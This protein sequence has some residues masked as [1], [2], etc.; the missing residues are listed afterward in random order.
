MKR[1]TI[2]FL[3]IIFIF[4]IT[5]CP[6]YGQKKS[7]E[8]S[9]SCWTKQTH[10][11]YR[12]TALENLFLKY[13]LEGDTVKMN[14]LLNKSVGTNY[15]NSDGDSPIKNAILSLNI[16]AVH[17]VLEKGSQ[18]SFCYRW[19][20]DF[21]ETYTEYYPILDYYKVLG[22]GTGQTASVA[23]KK[24]QYLKQVLDLLYE[25]GYRVEE[26]ISSSTLYS[27]LN[28]NKSKDGIDLYDF[29]LSK[30]M[31]TKLVDFFN[32]Y[33][34][35]GLIEAKDTFFY[36]EIIKRKADINISSNE[37]DAGGV[38]MVATINPPL[39]VA[40]ERGSL[41]T[42]RWLIEHGANVNFYYGYTSTHTTRRAN[43]GWGGNNNKCTALIT[44][45]KKKN[46]EMVKLLIEKGA[47]VNQTC[48]T[49]NSPLSEAIALNNNTMIEYLLEKG[50]KN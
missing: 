36:S 28:A 39:F 23:I 45:I 47:D 24:Q 20:N 7:K 13:C 10:P 12:L 19:V 26:S 48:P 37:Y 1:F 25:K 9:V 15:V 16:D 40:V 17:L 41:F 30:G 2:P 18:I 46:F 21:N 8:K 3:Y 6:L 32:I 22:Q 43:D 35:S 44:A 31:T 50:A 38:S 29:L 27:L 33:N 5:V 14:N 11:R 42:V 4:S 49:K 34:F